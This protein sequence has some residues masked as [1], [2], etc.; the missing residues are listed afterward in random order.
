M[1]ISSDSSSPDYRSDYMGAAVYL[2]GQLLDQVMVADDVA[3]E[4]VV[5]RKNAFGEVY[6]GRDGLIA[7]EV[8]KGTVQIVQSGSWPCAKQIGFD[9][10]MRIH[11]DAAHAAYMT[12]VA[13]L[14]R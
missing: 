9:A 3:G 6:V 5:A 10:W 1:R 11:T 13:A 4:V 14:P 12:R 7:T 8:R 2:N